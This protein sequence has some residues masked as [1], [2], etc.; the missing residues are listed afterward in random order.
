MSKG[1]YRFAILFHILIMF[2]L[3]APV[4]AQCTTSTSGLTWAPPTLTNP[5][6]V[7]I[8]GT[9]RTVILDS[10]KDYIIKMPNVVT[11]HLMIQGGRNIVMIGGEIN[12]INQ[13]AN[14]TIIDRTALKLR[15]NTGIVHIEGLLIHGED[16]TEGIQIAA[17]QAT[18]QLQNIRIEDVHAHDQVNFS[19]NHPDL[20]QSWGGYKALRVDQ[21]TG[22]SD[23]QGIFLKCD[24]GC[25]LGPTHLKRVNIIGLPTARYL[26][27]VNPAVGTGTVTLDNVWVDVPVE[28]QNGL[29][30]AVYPS[31]WVDAP[32]TATFLKDSGGRDYAVWNTLTTPRINGRVTEGRPTSGPNYVWRE[33]VGRAY[34]TPGYRCA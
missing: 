10:T 22:S 19:D 13:G 6:T 24:S 9:P 30:S 5:I 7:V 16:L 21:F 1:L 26:F 25:P 33:K 18:V 15:N 32:L 17:P 14:A 12:I 27:W 34:K 28:R 3:S 31:A 11:D 20:I 2:C 8:P 29:K 23:Y 4:N